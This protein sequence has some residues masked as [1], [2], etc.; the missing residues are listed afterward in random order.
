MLCL[1]VLSG[2]VPAAGL[3]KVVRFRA[4][5]K[6]IG[7]LAS[8]EVDG[9]GVGYTDPGYY[10]YSY[11]EEIEG[12]GSYLGA[13]ELGIEIDTKIG[14][15]DLLAGGAGVVNGVFA[16]GLFV[17]DAGYRFKLNRS[18]T[19]TLGPFVGIVVPGDT[20][21][22][23]DDS[24]VELEGN[25]GAQAGLKF[26]WGW[27]NVSFLLQGGYMGFTYDMTRPDDGNSWFYFDDENNDSSWDVGEKKEL[28]M[29]GFFADFGV[30]LQF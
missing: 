3:A 16:G 14:Y 19:V 23:V 13:A 20:E 1:L 28:D 4:E 11:T 2:L 17:A 7:F 6:P 10:S 5:I 29:S 22:E 12:G 27:E 24:T 21:W 15:L 9:L 8:P 25:G 30:S 18:G 26:T